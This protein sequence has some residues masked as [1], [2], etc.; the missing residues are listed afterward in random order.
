MFWNFAIHAPRLFSGVTLHRGALLAT[1]REDYALAER[2]FEC[3]AKRYRGELWVE[4]LARLRV[5]QEIARLRALKFSRR[6]PERC[7]EV[8]R[9][10]ARLERIEALEPPFELIDAEVLLASWL[11]GDGSTAESYGDVE[12]DRAA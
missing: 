4:P 12:L 7:L 11:K 5:H 9:S 8:E 10:L 1:Y 6:D 3:G 2:L